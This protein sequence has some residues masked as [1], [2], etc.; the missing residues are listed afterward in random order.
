[1]S[2]GSLRFGAG[3][4]GGNAALPGNATVHAGELAVDGGTRLKIDG[5]LTL[6]DGARLSL[7]AHAQDPALRA[8][9]VK[10]GNNV[11]LNLSGIASLDGT[12]RTLIASGDRIDGDFDAISVGGVAGPADYLTVNTS[13]SPDGK[14]YR[15][16]YDLSWTAA[17][18]L[19]HGSFTVD[20]L[21]TVGVGLTDQSVTA[22]SAWNGKTLTK[23]GAG[24]LVLTGDNRYTGG[25]RNTAGVLQIGDGG[26]T[27]SIL[28]D[29]V[30]DGTLVLN[31]AGAL[32]LAGN[33]SGAG[34]CGRSAR[35]P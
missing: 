29:V 17:N 9:E 33:I 10:I 11:A 8:G 19:A 35:A 1:M 12:P 6:A 14:E 16:A 28:G 4:N 31:R 22:G 21:F 30:N 26:L 24:T 23:A 20:G 3:D 5:R 2:G 7:A 25:T 27:G 18:N 15:V 34:G 13:K 32:T